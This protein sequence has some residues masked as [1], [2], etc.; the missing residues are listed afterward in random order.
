MA[1]NESQQ[2]TV[3]FSVN[4]VQNTASSTIIKTDKL[5]LFM[6]VGDKTLNIMLTSFYL[7]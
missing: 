6:S 4:G 7:L 2:L 3:K 5:T 1:N